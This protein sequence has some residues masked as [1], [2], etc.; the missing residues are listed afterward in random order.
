MD[1]YFVAVHGQSSVKD[2]QIK[3]FNDL[4]L[5]VEY[6][7]TCKKE[8]NV[9]YLSPVTLFTVEDDVKFWII[10]KTRLR[11]TAGERNTD[12]EFYFDRNKALLDYKNLEKDMLLLLNFKIYGPYIIHKNIMV[13]LYKEQIKSYTEGDVE[14][15]TLLNQFTSLSVSREPLSRREIMP[16]QERRRRRSRSRSP[17]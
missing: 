3:Y 12:L 7:D 4:A 2:Y 13:R 8:A 17:R 15:N 16:F 9:L 1:Y 6:Y 10:V 5:A 11:N 14:V